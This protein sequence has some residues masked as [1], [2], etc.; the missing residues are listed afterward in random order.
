MLKIKSFV[1]RLLNVTRFKVLE[2]SQVEILY[3]LST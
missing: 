2:Y 3:L 1:Y